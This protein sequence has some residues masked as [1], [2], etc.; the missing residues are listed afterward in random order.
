MERRESV[1]LRRGDALVVVDVQNCFLPGGALGVPEGDAV[2]PL[3]NRYITL[4]READLPIIATRDWHPEDHCS[5]TAQGGAWPPHCIAGTQGAAFAADLHLPEG[6]LVISKATEPQREAYSG[7]DTTGLAE[8]LREMEV[9]R[10][11]IGGLATDYCVLATVEHALEAG[12]TAVV[13]ADAVRAVNLRPGDG[14]KA[15]ERMRRKGALLLTIEEVA[16]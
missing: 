14:E 8:R 11:F 9:N 15:L 13:L 12:F 4:F 3:L 7:F 10:L 1:R 6:A 2:V 16:P 5:F